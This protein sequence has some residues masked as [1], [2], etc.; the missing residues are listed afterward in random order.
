MGGAGR[1]GLYFLPG[2][3]IPRSRGQASLHCLTTGWSSGSLAAEI[4]LGG[5]MIRWSSYQPGFA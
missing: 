3:F 4:R 2:G 1:E 5:L